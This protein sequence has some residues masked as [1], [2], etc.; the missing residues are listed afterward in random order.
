MGQL[1]IHKKYILLRPIVSIIGSPTHALSHFLAYKLQAFI[2]KTSSFIKDSIDFIHKTQNLH[3]DDDNLMVSFY[4]VSMFTKIP[5]SEALTLI[6]KL[7][8]PETLNLI[9]MCLSFTFF[10]FKGV[11]YE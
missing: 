1:K 11:F 3:L 8:D 2:G 7:V 5:I 9:K 4:V 6:S 10:T